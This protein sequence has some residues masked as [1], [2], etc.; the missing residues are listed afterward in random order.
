[1]RVHVAGHILVSG[2]GLN[3]KKSVAPLCVCKDIE[4]VKEK[5]TPG[6]IIVVPGTS[7]LKK[8]QSDTSFCQFD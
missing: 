1:M 4:Q 3:E 6:D 2:E 8:T 5:F 7:E